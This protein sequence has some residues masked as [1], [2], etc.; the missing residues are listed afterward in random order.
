MERSFLVA[1]TSDL[2]VAR[3]C[4]WAYSDGKVLSTH[5]VA[6]GDPLGPW[7]FAIGLEKLIEPLRESMNG[8]FDIWYAD[9]GNLGAGSAVIKV[10]YAL[11]STLFSGVLKVNSGSG[12]YT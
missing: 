5:G 11:K 1:L 12:L 2:P 8:C 6:Q 4:H 9:D 7:L 3:L 10:F